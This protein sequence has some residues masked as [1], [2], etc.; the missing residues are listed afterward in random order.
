MPFYYDYNFSR[1]ALLDELPPCKA[2]FSNETPKGLSAGTLAGILVGAV[3]VAGK[4]NF[5]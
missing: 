4:A 3:A 2:S 5:P 1:P